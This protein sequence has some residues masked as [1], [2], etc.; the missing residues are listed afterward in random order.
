MSGYTTGSTMSGKTDGTNSSMDVDSYDGS[1]RA[2][3]NSPN[4]SSQGTSAYGSF[5][6]KTVCDGRFIVLDTLGSGA[7]AKVKL[8]VD[9]ISTK[10]VALKLM[11]K[12]P[13][14]KRQA[15]QIEREITGESQNEQS[16]ESEEQSDE[17]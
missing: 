10:R 16:D 3:Q 6:R 2:D 4:K 8:G 1:S 14:S 9:T 11:N 13:N 17:N 5:Q 12:R 15:D 7:T